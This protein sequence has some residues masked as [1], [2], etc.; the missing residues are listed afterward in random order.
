MP[1]I[2]EKQKMNVISFNVPYP[3]DYGGVIDVFYKIKSL[4]EIGVEVILHTFEYGRPHA[5]EL[6][7]YCSE[8]HYYRRTTG[9]KSQLTLLPYIVKSRADKLLLSNL[10]KN[11]CPILFEGLHSCFYLDKPELKDRLKIVRMHNI[12]HNYYA[13]LAKTSSRFFD[14]LFFCVEA[15][16]LKLFQSVL[17]HADVILPLSEHETDYF[18]RKFGSEKTLF[19]PIFHQN[20]K[21][22]IRGKIDRPYLI[23]HGDLSVP[24]NINAAIYLID[25]VAK[26]D[27]SLELVIAGRHPDS[28]LMEKAREYANITVV[29][30]PGNAAMQKLI[31]DASIN[32]LY[33]EHAAG[34]KLKLLQSLYNGR[35]CMANAALTEGSM[36]ENL[37]IMMP[38][39]KTRLLEAVH[40]YYTKDFSAAEI[41][42]REITL[43]KFY[44]NRKNARKI[45]NLL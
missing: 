29:A 4:C 7:R 11:D 40:R 36:L 25:N 37:C 5:D 30:N 26:Q 28:K 9:W 34:V 12:E 19:V 18:N 1:D 35:F 10:L 41:E 43:E 15:F 31:H 22:N 42:E 14:K 44:N 2:C 13:A 23:F 32:I 45:A 33:V 24:E 39:D 20:G 27:K 21:I 17:K 38:Q 8:V 3:A 6:N 16:R